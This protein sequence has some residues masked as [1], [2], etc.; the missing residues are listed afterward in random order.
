MPV[1]FDGFDS[2][3]RLSTN[4]PTGVLLQHEAK[5]VSDRCVVVYDQDSDIH[6]LAGK[7]PVDRQG[8]AQSTKSSAGSAV[9][10]PWFPRRLDTLLLAKGIG[11]KP[12]VFQDYRVLPCQKVEERQSATG[13]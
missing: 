12:L 9:P 2:V 10:I 7:F 13:S 3:F 8:S 6:R 11:S 4:L 5:T 1:F